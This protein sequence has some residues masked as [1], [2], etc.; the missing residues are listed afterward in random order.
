MYATATLSGD[1]ANALS[2]LK[3]LTKPAS[4]KAQRG[5]LIPPDE[6]AN[7]EVRH[8]MTLICLS[9]ANGCPSIFPYL[10]LAP[11]QRKSKL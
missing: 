10:W 6:L 11:L 1:V 2:L 3:R 9:N 7:C 4:R 5:L 8:L